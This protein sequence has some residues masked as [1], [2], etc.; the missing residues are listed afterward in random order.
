MPEISIRIDGLAELQS[1]C[2][3]I[4]IGIPQEAKNALIASTDVVR[5]KAREIAPYKTGNLRR[6][7][8]SKVSGWIG[9][10]YVEAV[11]GAAVEFGRAASVITP[12]LKKALAFRIN[13]QLVFARRVN[14]PGTQPKPYLKPALE[15]S[16]NHIER[17]FQDAIGK[18][19]K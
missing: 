15:S 8:K 7:I 16:K 4:A 18:L 1:R 17:I 10:I 9:L 14:H 12:I 19:F 13:G 5:N 2:E 11:Y 6:S 3:K